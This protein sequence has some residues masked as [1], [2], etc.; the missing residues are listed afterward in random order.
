MARW[1]KFAEG[2]SGG[3]ETGYRF[4]DK[5]K[6][7]RKDKKLRG[8][9]KELSAGI[10]ELS[11]P[12]EFSESV[13]E[14]VPVS[15]EQQSGELAAPPPLDTPDAGVNVTPATPVA[16]GNQGAGVEVP[17]AAAGSA[18]PSPVPASPG[19]LPEPAGKS[20]S[21]NL[22]TTK[23]IYALRMEM[24]N[25]YL[26]AGDIDGF[27]K[28][29]ESIDSHLHQQFITHGQQAK[30]ML[31]NGDVQGAGKALKRAYSFF[32]NG[33]GVDLTMKDGNLIGIGYEEGEDGSPGK[34]KGAS[35]VTSDS[36][37]RMI[38]NFK[39]PEAYAQWDVT[40]RD[41]MSAMAHR[42][43]ASDRADKTLGLNNVDLIRREQDSA[44]R[45]SVDQSR[46]RLLETQTKAAVS[47]GANAPDDTEIRN[48]ATAVSKWV[49]SHRG[50]HFANPGS[51]YP[52]EM[53][54][55]GG[56]RVMDRSVWEMYKAQ[57]AAL[58]E[59]EAMA[60][61]LAAGQRGEF[62][63]AEVMRA[64]EAARVEASAK[65]LHMSLVQTRNGYG[66]AFADEKTGAIT[67][68]P[69]G[70]SG[71]GSAVSSGNTGEAIATGN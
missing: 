47:G 68:R 62:N 12:V 4:G 35:V 10:E 61:R 23:D 19:A 69:W 41:V 28:A 43:K 39:D 37:D 55:A 54:E 31:D 9:G 14:A 25:V 70:G 40:S 8:T 1:D 20:G 17:P 32:P 21:F 64:I 27:V 29:Q 58:D 60:V 2:F 48:A 52:M 50:V 59:N 57:P 44:S 15:N 16:A 22:P 38:R 45:R 6:E 18:P 71:T 49:G 30:A 33:T 46:I 66:F 63:P 11:G 65:G 36:I 56:D 13:P 67:M 34:F 53:D 3:L 26:E 42:Q 7:G 5:L 24:A 51:E